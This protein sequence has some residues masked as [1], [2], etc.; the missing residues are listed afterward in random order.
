MPVQPPIPP[1]PASDFT[2]SVLPASVTLT[3]GATSQPLVFS[4]TG[5]NG[6]TGSVQVSL[7]G[8]P[9]GVSTNPIG[10]FSVEAGGNRSVI[11]GVS[12]TT[13]TGTFTLS[14]QAS[15]GNLS[16]ATS[17]ALT[18]QTGTQL[19]TPSRTGFVRI[20]STPVSDI[21]AGEPSHRR[22]VYDSVQKRIFVA[23]RFMNRVDVFS[24]EQ[25]LIAR[26]AVPEPTSVD[27][28][29]D[30]KKIW[31]GTSA[32]QIVDIDAVSLQASRNPV[33]G[34]VT[35]LAR[36][37]LPQEIVPL[38]NETMLVSL[39][40]AGTQNTRLAR[41]DRLNNSFAEISPS[42][43]SGGPGAMAR[44]GDH[45]KA[46]VASNN[47]TGTLF[48]YEVQSNSFTRSA[49]FVGSTP[50]FVAADRDG[51]RFAAYLSSV[52]GAQ[53]ALLD[54]TLKVVAFH[55]LR[56]AQGLVFSADGRFLYISED[57]D[58]PAV[59]AILDARTGQSVGQIPDLPLGGM[60]SQIQDADESS[61]IFGISNRGVSFLDAAS[62]RQFAPP[63]SRF[64]GAS[65]VTPANGSSTGGTAV[66]LA[67]QNF[68]SGTQ[69]FF[70][71]QAA[72]NVTV[73]S[74]IQVLATTPPVANVGPVHVSAVSPSGWMA[75]APE[76]FSYGP[77][78]VRLLTTA[79]SPKGDTTVE[80][81]GYGFGSSVSQLSVSV[82]GQAAT[83]KSLADTPATLRALGLPADYPFPIEMLT[84]QT[85]PGTPGAA[86]LAI[87]SA[88]G[89]TN[90]AGAFHYLKDGQ[91][92][93]HAGLYKFILYDQKR[94]R[95]YLSNID[96]V[97]VFDLNAAKFIAP[98]N[99]PGGDPPC[100]GGPPPNAELRGLGL[101]ADGSQLVVAD[102]G[103][104]MVYL[105]NLDAPGTGTCVS[106]GG[107]P[108]FLNSGPARVAATSLRNVFVAMAA[109]TAGGCSQCLGVLDPSTKSIQLPSQPEVSKL[110]G[111][112]IVQSADGG[113]SVFL[114]FGGTRG[115]PV[116][117]WQSATN[118]FQNELGNTSSSDLAVADDGNIFVTGKN[119]TN[120]LPA[121]KIW[122]P[123]LRLTGRGL[124]HELEKLP[125]MAGVPGETMHPSGGL[126]YQPF[127]AAH[128]GEA[129]IRGGVDIFDVRSGMVRERMFF[130]EQLKTERDAL[131]GSF[132]T[133]DETGKRIFAI[134]ESGLSIL[135]LAG[136]PISIGSVQPRRGPASGGTILTIRGSGF[137]NGT[138]GTKVSI[139]GTPVTTTFVDAN[140]LRVTTPSLS[141]GAQRITV[142]NLDGDSATFDAAFVAN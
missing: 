139:G 102:F 111:T 25:E 49:Q 118:R 9:A 15:S 67:G 63:Y 140:T 52:S 42:G 112:P 129:T 34:L 62:P 39:R 114:V 83:V 23:N 18:V 50:V 13:A 124:Y 136:A 4:V 100:P 70:G 65:V 133:V 79:G 41:W 56:Q 30:G 40:Q 35:A 108:G 36:F 80:V 132:L 31:V 121:P 66:S 104:Q 1:P 74:N 109:E 78:V 88:S 81:I 105:M 120:G 55:A 93:R 138:N 17:L 51:S 53:V 106:V 6:F 85:P 134:T 137:Q 5:T 3:Q 123:D 11:L 7:G 59:I 29:A 45:T 43:L 14:V 57:S 141:S 131:H 76:A 115:G 142:I 26:I 94:Q 122:G 71:G 127:T 32:E 21:S 73:P 28:S 91:V 103:A 69:V 16:H 119:E 10:T 90:V 33:G 2:I 95:V 37:G 98:L 135:E 22:I 8:I 38:T 84:I 47:S 92:F 99:P 87:T 101:T 54:G 72:S 116:A 75:F 48:L 107:V 96:H 110:T 58:G 125:G 89:K 60:R 82:G 61:R 126:L 20:D 86:D 128:P 117:V 64:T 113:R 97:D 24:P 130:S 27:L 12:A 68:V 77:H 46:L 19:L 44:S